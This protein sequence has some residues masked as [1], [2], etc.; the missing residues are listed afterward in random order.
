MC[1]KRIFAALLAVLMV[2]SAGVVPARAAL[3]GAYL[4]DLAAF[5]GSE[6]TQNEESTYTKYV[7]CTYSDSLGTEPLEEYLALLQEDRYHLKLIKTGKE[8]QDGWDPAGTCRD[9]FFEYTGSFGNIQWITTQSGDS[10]HVKVTLHTYTNKDFNAIVLYREPDFVLTDSGVHY[11]DK[12]IP[13]LHDFF[14]NAQRKEME[15]GKTSYF[16][17]FSSKPDSRVSDFEEA[18]KSAGLLEK[19]NTFFQGMGKSALLGM[20]LYLYYQAEDVVVISIRWHEADKE[21]EVILHDDA[22]KEVG[23]TQRTTNVGEDASASGGTQNILSV[24]DFIKGGKKNN[25][26]N[27]GGDGVIDCYNCVD[28]SCYV[29]GGDGYV[30]RFTPG[31]TDIE[32]CM[33]CILGDCRVC[34]GRGTRDCAYC[35]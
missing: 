8:Y 35:G 15:D 27:C 24:P 2:L 21:L 3:L 32:V 29:C 17:S 31:R 18:L 4:P 12:K 9:Y 1:R 22:L 6:Y 13:A 20:G 25:C 7:T 14:G 19:E 33:M 5:L 26:S 34:K 28:G 10:Y 16:F 30:Y 11:G 23:Y